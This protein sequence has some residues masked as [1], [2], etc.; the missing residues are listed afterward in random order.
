MKPKIIMHINY[1]EQGQTVPEICQK[2]V[3]WGFDGVEFRRKR[4]GIEE[5]VEEYLDNI[6]RAAAKAKMKRVIFGEPGPDLMVAGAN[7]RRRELKEVIE[8]YRLAAVR[9]KL[10]TCNI[11]AGA[12]LNP[13]KNVPYERY[14]LHGSQVATREQ[15]DWTV[16][17]FKTLGTLAEKLGFRLAFET[18]MGYLHDLP[19]AAKKLSD[20]IGSPAIG[21]NLDYANYI[22]FPNHLS[23]RETIEE[24]GDRLYYVHLKNSI[25]AGKNVR[26]P[27]GLAQGEINNREFLGILKERGYG[28]HICIE[29]P[30]PG[31]RE[32]YA[33][34]DI[35]YLKSLIKDIKWT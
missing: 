21:V 32:Y 2:A 11:T 14:E 5:S 22:N 16:S 23:I 7:E 28:G 24:M 30:R 27:S 18:H 6:V 31:D 29:A 19:R 8:F 3:D 4:R 1:C 13:D 20:L 26:F 34:Q 17:G 9:F 15:W 25:S 10:T 35:A 12:L 33:Q